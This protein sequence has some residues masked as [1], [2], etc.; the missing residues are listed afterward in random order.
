MPQGNKVPS[1]IRDD[2]LDSALADPDASGIYKET[3]QIFVEAFSE[4]VLGEKLLGIG[5]RTRGLLER[6]LQEE[7]PEE[8]LAGLIAATVDAC[9]E[10]PDSYFGTDAGYVET[11]FV[12][13]LK[14]LE[15][16]LASLVGS[17]KLRD[18]TRE[19][20]RCIDG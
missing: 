14:E 17:E 3:L 5:L 13:W 19:L 18:K 15:E 7:S 20:R 12:P 6:T 16:W 11:F 2:I 4:S 8:P 1:V 10:I 9:R